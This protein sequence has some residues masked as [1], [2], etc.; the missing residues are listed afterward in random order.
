MGRTRWLVLLAGVSALALTQSFS[1]AADTNPQPVDNTHNVLDAPAPVTGASFATTVSGTSG[2]ALCHTATSSDAN[3]NTDCA[4]PAGIGP[5]NETSIAVDPNDANHI[6]GGANDYQLSFNGSHLDETIHSRAH[7]T[8]DGG[9]TW[10][11]F[12]IFSNSSYTATGDPSVAFDGH[13]NV[14]YATLGFRFVSKTNAQNPDVL[15]AHSSDGGKSWNEVRVASGSGLFTSAGDLLDKEYIAAWGNGNVIITYGDFHQD[16]HGVTTSVD[17]FSQVSH[18]GGVSW[19]E[20][21]LISGSLHESFGSMPVVAADGKVYAAFLNT[22]NLVTGRD[23][24]EFLR[25]DPQTGA[26]I[27]GTFKTIGTLVDGFFDYPIEF[28]R[29]TYQDSVFRNGLPVNIAADPTNAAHLAAIWSDMRNS[30]P[31]SPSDTSPYDNKTNSDVVFSQT[32]DSGKTWSAPA[33]L[34]IPNDQFMPWGAFDSTGALRIGFFDRQYDKNNHL[35]DYTLATEDVAEST[36]P[37][38]SF[39]KV[40][41]QSSD[42]TQGDR[43]F[44]GRSPS[45]NPAFQHPTSFMGDYS[46]IAAV[47]GGGVVAYWTDMRVKNVCFPPRCG[48][49]EDAFFASLK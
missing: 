44:S 36:T 18:D 35:Y 6:V 48:T 43:W 11:L 28:G 17:I 15:V 29:Q 5:H 47:P 27:S 10:S 7:V 30:T 19:S 31:V 40:T 21:N 41:T 42:P 26:P 37:T 25:L 9:K 13:G 23:D 24:Y 49:G 33:A 1:A 8:F 16:A 2:I 4:D 46:N 45:T 34:A 22:T 3:V 14:Y 12:N 39:A 32:F 38:F 20:P